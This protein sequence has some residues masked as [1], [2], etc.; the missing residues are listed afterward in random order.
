MYERI[1][2]STWRF[3]IEEG[4]SGWEIEEWADE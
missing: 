4:V 2:F 3:R 1:V